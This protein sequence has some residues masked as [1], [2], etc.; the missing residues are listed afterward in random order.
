LKFIQQSLERHIKPGGKILG[1]GCGNG[2]ISYQ[3]AKNGFA[4]TG[5]DIG[6]DAIAEAKRTYQM[7]NLEFIAVRAEDI[8]TF[9]DT[10]FDALICSEVIEHLTAPEKL[11]LLFSKYLKPGGV[12]AVTVPN[13]FGP[14]EV[15]ITKP[16][17]RMNRGQGVMYKIVLGFKRFLG[18]QAG[19][20]L[21]KFSIYLL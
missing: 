12:V 3:L 9:R 4:V 16:F 7:S 6:K 11:T 2:N 20:S 10:K 21:I 1:I 13:D 18:Y 15:L 19:Q 17:Q 14:R 5:M 8:A